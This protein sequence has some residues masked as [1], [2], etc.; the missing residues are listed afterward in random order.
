MKN[1]SAQMPIYFYRF[2]QESQLSIVLNFIESRSLEPQIYYNY[3]LY[4]PRK[5][6]QNGGGVL[7]KKT[8]SS[9]LA[10]LSIIVSLIV[11]L[12]T[13]FYGIAAGQGVSGAY[14]GAGAGQ[15][16]YYGG[17]PGGSVT[18]QGLEGLQGFTSGANRLSLA[19]QPVKQQGN[20]MF[21]QIV[22]F[23]IGDPQSGQAVAYAL[24]QPMVGVADPSQN[25]MQIDISNIGSAISQAGYVSAS[26]IY[27]A[28]RTDPSIMVIDIDMTY[29]GT[30]GYQTIFN[31]N[32]ITMIPPDGRAQ[33]FQMQQPTQLIID[34]QSYRISMVTFPQMLSVFGGFYGPPP[35]VLGPV[36]L[37]GPIFITPPIFVPFI[38]PIPV[39]FAPVPFAFAFAGSF[40]SNFFTPSIF[41]NQFAVASAA[42]SAAAFGGNAAAA[43]SA[44]ASAVSGG[45]ICGGCGSCIRY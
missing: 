15:Q 43:A 20:Q 12:S 36:A 1:E 4:Y 3:L 8:D 21:F 14:A 29:Q 45:G 17:G 41:T 13:Q 35:A 19:I 38:V 31:V 33:T 24:N 37:G 25:T 32:A 22:G 5:I 42:A 16:G 27:D 9:R 6:V 10:A 7:T 2:M 18:I 44:A 30:Q 28:L 23:A 40:V 11:I 34:A 26:N 39:L